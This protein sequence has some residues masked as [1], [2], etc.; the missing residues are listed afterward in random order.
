MRKDTE[1]L[2]KEFFKDNYAFKSHKSN[3]TCEPSRLKEHFEKHFQLPQHLVMPKEIAEMPQY[4]KH[5]QDIPVDSMK[6][7][8]PDEEEIRDAIKKSL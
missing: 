7:G 3:E 2:F 5:L 6:Q 1:K 8:P 4:M